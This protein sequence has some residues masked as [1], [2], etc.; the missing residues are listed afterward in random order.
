MDS[1][2]PYRKLARSLP[3]DKFIAQYAH[4]FLVKHPIGSASDDPSGDDPWDDRFS[5]RTRVFDD[6]DDPDL[7]DEF[8]PIAHEWRVVEVKKREGNPFPERISVGRAKNCDV[9]LRFP[10][11]SKLHAHFLVKTGDPVYRLVDQRSANGTRVRG[12]AIDAGATVTVQEGDVIRFG[13]VDLELMGPGR[14]HSLLV[15]MVG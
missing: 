13:G 12:K 8:G 5:F 3:R 6:P 9:V 1:L 4:P 15:G 10:S 11:V 7:E 2:D 14:F